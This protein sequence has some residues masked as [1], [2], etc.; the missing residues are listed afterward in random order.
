MNQLLD[1]M[2]FLRVVKAR[3]AVDQREHQQSEG[4]Q[5]RRQ[6]ACIF[7]DVATSGHQI[8]NCKRRQQSTEQIM[9]IENS[10][11]RGAEQNRVLHVVF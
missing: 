9:K 4:P 11:C 1:Y 6:L 7:L 2:G 10:R 8:I 5:H 3:N